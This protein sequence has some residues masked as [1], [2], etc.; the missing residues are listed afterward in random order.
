MRLYGGRKINRSIDRRF[1]THTESRDA[2]VWDVDQPNGIAR[3][4]VQGS[5]KLIQCHYPQNWQT[6]PYYVKPG[7]AIRII[8]KGGQ[9][10]FQEISGPGRAIPSPVAGP[11]IPPTPP[12]FNGIMTGMI[13]SA[14]GGGMYINLT[15]GTFRIRGIT[16]TFDIGTGGILMGGDGNIMDPVTGMP[17]GVG[18]NA[19]LLF[20][21]APAIPNARYD[22]VVVAADGIADI[23]KGTASVNPVMPVVPADHIEVFHV[24]ILG[25]RT[26]LTSADIN[27]EWE[28]RSFHYMTFALSGQYAQN[29]TQMKCSLTD[30]APVIDIIITFRCQYNWAFSMA[31]NVTLTKD[32][33]TGAIC[34]GYPNPWENVAPITKSGTGSTTT[35]YYRRA[36][37]LFDPAPPGG[38]L[39][40][41]HTGEGIVYPGD[42]AKVMFRVTMTGYF[43][44]NTSHTIDLLFTI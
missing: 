18:T 43:G 1:R 33:G 2:I 15:N 41:D 32:L 42:I 35:F 20:D 30:A 27:A 44:I 5:D 11:V 39:E 8:H 22:L 6:L 12:L 14:P 10:G 16:Y 28:P 17:M 38:P 37:V 23:V 7:F 13:P 19:T 36:E 4:K 24:L 40:I 9:K 3:C 29:D 26:E 21:A 31:Y 34:I 25:G